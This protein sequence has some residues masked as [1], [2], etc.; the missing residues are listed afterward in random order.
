MRVKQHSVRL[1]HILDN[2]G[3]LTFINT[4]SSKAP[5]HNFEYIWRE[6]EFS[7]FC[8]FTH[9]AANLI[10][11][12][13]RGFKQQA[14]KITRHLNIH[15]R[16]RRSNDIPDFINA[17][18][19]NARKDVIYICRNHELRDWKA[20]LLSN[21]SSKN[22]TEITCRNRKGNFFVWPTQLG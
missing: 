1:K 20:H 11:I 7:F 8:Q 6:G 10:S 17:C 2:F 3:S 19:Q 15:T 12:P 16:T 9:E 5:T 14:F 22:I 21:I 13:T 4:L 18:L